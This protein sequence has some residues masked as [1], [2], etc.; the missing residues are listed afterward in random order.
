MDRNVVTMNGDNRTKCGIMP[1][2][3]ITEQNADLCLPYIQ[4]LSESI[5][6]RTKD[7]QVRVVSTTCCTQRK[8]LMKLRDLNNIKYVI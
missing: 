6:K 8:L 7:L 5:E 2:L 3:V 1:T 4:G